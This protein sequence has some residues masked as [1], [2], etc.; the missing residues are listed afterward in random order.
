MPPQFSMTPAARMTGW[1]WAMASEQQITTGT[2]VRHIRCLLIIEFIW[3]WHFTTGMTSHSDDS[4]NS[5]LGTVDTRYVIGKA[6]FLLFP[7]AD[8]VTQ[9]RDFGRIG[10]IGG[11]DA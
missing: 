9:Q 3:S 7:G 1:M 10:L 11:V 2:I 4:R 8:E 5:Q 6:V